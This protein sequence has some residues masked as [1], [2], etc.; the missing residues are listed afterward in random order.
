M[1]IDTPVAT[2]GIRGTAVLVEI[3]F[4]VPGQSGQPDAKFQV[5]VEPDGTTGSYV[6][7][8]KTTLQPLAV[9]NQAGQ[10]INISQ[11]VITQTNAPLSPD[12]QKLIN[13]V[14][15]LKFADNTN[16]K[17]NTG[18]NNSITPQTGPVTKTADSG[19]TA[20][21]KFVVLADVGSTPA[22][23][24]GGKASGSSHI[25]G[26]PE[27]RLLDLAGNLTTGFAITERIGI[28]GDGNRSRQHLRQ[29]GLRRP[30]CRRYADRAGEFQRLHLSE[31]AAPGRHGQ[32]EPAAACRRRGD[33]R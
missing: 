4:T 1:K 26:P 17:T 30:Q 2:M 27:A 6:L 8:D 10:Q 15:T 23:N 22:S 32:S 11:G 33:Q 24:S 9:V 14:F 18:Q 31:C 13:D 28:T 3:D 20:I 19:A 7:F 16:P 12:V 29:G 5:L 21:P 25:P